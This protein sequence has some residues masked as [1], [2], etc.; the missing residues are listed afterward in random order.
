M[1]F[2]FNTSCFIVNEHALSV[3]QSLATEVNTPALLPPPRPLLE[4]PSVAPCL[5]RRD[6]CILCALARPLSAHGPSYPLLYS[7]VFT[8][9]SAVSALLPVGASVFSWCLAPSGRVD[10][11]LH[12]AQVWSQERGEMSSRSAGRAPNL[13]ALLC[14]HWLVYV[15]EQLEFLFNA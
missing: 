2:G 11:G 7:G 8:L 15:P 1:F 10:R 6:F 14:F 3:I 12:T 9:R 13:W 5:S 4:G